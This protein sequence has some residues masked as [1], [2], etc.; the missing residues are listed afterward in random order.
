M[1]KLV[2]REEDDYLWAVFRSSLSSVQKSCQQN[3]FHVDRASG[4]WTVR[5]GIVLPMQAQDIY[6]DVRNKEIV[7]NGILGSDFN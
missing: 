2:G 7:R 6:E 1:K 4:M 3:G 5:G